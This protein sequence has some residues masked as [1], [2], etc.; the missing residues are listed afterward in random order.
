MSRTGAR[1]WA[2]TVAGCVLAFLAAY[3]VANHA[4][5]SIRLPIGSASVAGLIAPNLPSVVVD[6][7][8]AVYV[9]WVTPSVELP[10]TLYEVQRSSGPGAG[11]IIC[12]PETVA[13]GS[14]AACPDLA[15][16]PGTRYGYLVS[17]LI[18]NRWQSSVGVYA[19]TSDITYQLSVDDS[20]PAAGQGFA[21]TGI[22]AVHPDGSTVDRS[23]TGRKTLRWSGLVT[24]PAGNGP[25]Y[26]GGGVSSVLFTDGVASVGGLDFASEDEG[27]NLL[28]ATQVGGANVSAS[29]AATITVGWGPAV[30]LSFGQQP[31]GSVLSGQELTTSPQVYVVD[32]YGNLVG[33]AGGSVSLALEG[34][35]AA[36]RCDGGG[37]DGA[38]A[39]FGVATYTGCRITGAPGS[40]RLAAKA[41][42][43]N[44]AQSDPVEISAG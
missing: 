4:A 23:Y 39:D 9:Q 43:L 17:A 37:P 25:T 30:G 21:V 11:T 40:Y 14:T 31:S 36:L 38:T 35:G 28:V 34:A 10:G 16:R 20:A 8:G 5:R 22:T 18:G 29:G 26:P 13:P 42:G 6:G 12:D 33:S 1:R 44:G 3:L 19:T 7:S 32:T 27:P 24:S 41:A 15:V 2:G